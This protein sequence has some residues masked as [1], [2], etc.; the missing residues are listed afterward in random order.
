MITADKKPHTFLRISS[1]HGKSVIKIAFNIRKRNDKSR[2]IPNSLRKLCGI[3]LIDTSIGEI[4]FVAQAINGKSAD[5]TSQKNRQKNTER[6]K[7]YTDEKRNDRRNQ[8]KKKV[9]DFFLKLFRQIRFPSARAFLKAR[10]KQ[11]C[12]QNPFSAFPSLS[13]SI[14]VQAREPPLI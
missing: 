13:G 10:R 14:C 9:H 7:K 6:N 8:I 12:A 11:F 2:W 3:A 5:P 1:V 4:P